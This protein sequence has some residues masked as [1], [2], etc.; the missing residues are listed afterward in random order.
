M[1]ILINGWSCSG[2]STLAKHVKAL[3]EE[4][5]GWKVVILD[6]DE[7]R[8][9][10]SFDSDYSRHG[11]YLNS[12][13]IFGAASLLEQQG[14]A[15]V[16]ASINIFPELLVSYRQNFENYLEV[17]LQVSVHE[18]KGRDVGGV[19]RKFDE[20]RLISVA[21]LDL[22]A[23]QSMTADV[24]IENHGSNGNWS[25]GLDRLKTAISAMV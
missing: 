1:V 19:Y 16:V 22:E 6:G 3:L 8:K 25:E 23:P 12:K 17:F 13:R 7:C 20:G 18:L 10:I 2:K 9:K 5:H 11:R 14:L 21:G 4:E 15:V 24:V